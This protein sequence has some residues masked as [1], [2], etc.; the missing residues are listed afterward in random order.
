MGRL[1]PGT[2]V[3]VMRAACR[4][5]LR[6]PFTGL[7]FIIKTHQNQYSTFEIFTPLKAKTTPPFDSSQHVGPALYRILFT[8]IHDVRMSPPPVFLPQVRNIV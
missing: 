5:N 8:D 4:E 6:R 7:Q 2:E 3:S 1:Q